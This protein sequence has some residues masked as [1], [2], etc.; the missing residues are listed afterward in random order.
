MKVD[1]SK[2]KKTPTEAVS[3]HNSTLCPYLTFNW[4]THAELFNDQIL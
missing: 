4:E 2:L 3:M 1:R